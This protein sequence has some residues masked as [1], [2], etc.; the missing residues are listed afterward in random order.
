MQKNSLDYQTWSIY[1]FVVDVVHM[2]SH[3]VKV[4]K[5]SQPSSKTIYHE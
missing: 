1:Y 5:E 3:C 2:I 4:E